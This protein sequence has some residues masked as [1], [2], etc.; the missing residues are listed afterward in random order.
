[1]SFKNTKIRPLFSISYVEIIN[2]KIG[3]ARDPSIHFF[4]GPAEICSHCAV[5][6]M[7]YIYILTFFWQFHAGSFASGAS[8]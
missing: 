1:M 8:L 3:D 6:H 5:V 4:I 2:E 7:R